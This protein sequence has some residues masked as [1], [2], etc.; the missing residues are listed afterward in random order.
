[1]WC[2]CHARQ[3]G[4]WSPWLGSHSSA[5][6]L[7]E[8]SRV[9]WLSLP[10]ASSEKAGGQRSCLRCCSEKLNFVNGKGILGTLERRLSQNGDLMWQLPW[11]FWISWSSICQADLLTGR[12]SQVRMSCFPAWCHNLLPTRWRASYFSSPRLSF[13]SYKVDSITVS[14]PNAFCGNWMISCLWRA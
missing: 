3:G 11:D 9:H 10:Q 4:K 14:T 13:L 2:P 1:M 6:V 12:S 7:H 8:S 5:I